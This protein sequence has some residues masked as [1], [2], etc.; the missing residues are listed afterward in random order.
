MTAR[1]ERLGAPQA[2]FYFRNHL[3]A[4]ESF[5]DAFAAG[6]SAPQKSIPCRF[7]YDPAGSALFDKICELPEYYQ[8]RTELSI[9]SANAAAIAHI[10][11]RDAALIELGSGSSVKTRILLD[12]LDALS[13]YA[14]ID[15]SAEHLKGAAM[16]IARDYPGLRIEAIAADYA[17]DFPLPEAAGR[18]IAFFPGSTIGNMTRAQARALLRGWR[19]RLGPGGLMIVGVDLKKDSKTLNAAY[20][21]A[22][23]VSE[24]FTRNI[25]TRA[26]REL[27]G[28]FDQRNFLYLARYDAHAGRVEMRLKSRLA[29]VVR[30]A[31]RD[32]VFAEGEILHVEDSHKYGLDEFAALAGEAGFAP[33]ARYADPA[34]L[35]SVHVIAA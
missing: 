23:G 18:R 13:C 12:H 16:R 11:G 22:A 15:V 34:R 27:C 1:L 3:V 24:A 35:F 10:A 17:G 33:V 19:A 7:L 29:H 5:R 21:D 30:A 8:T 4:Q 2:P 9:L 28:D 25:L 14:P 32:W 6:M 26:N 31:G 20:N